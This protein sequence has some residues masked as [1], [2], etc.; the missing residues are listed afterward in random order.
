MMPLPALSVT[1][2]V[3]SVIGAA[4]VMLPP[5]DVRVS[6]P[7]VSIGEPSEKL[8]PLVMLTGAFPA[9]T[10]HCIGTRKLSVPTGSVTVPAVAVSD[11][12]ALFVAIGLVT[13]RL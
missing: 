9:D 7:V 5:V 6:D 11:T 12:A 2:P 1:T 3:V 10:I 13:V 8:L 4:M